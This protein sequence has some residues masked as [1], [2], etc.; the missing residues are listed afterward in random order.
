MAE[1]PQLIYAINGRSVRSETPRRLGFYQDPA[2]GHIQVAIGDLD[3]VAERSI[4]VSIAEL[5]Q[6]L[7]RIPAP[8]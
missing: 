6:A 7:N 8:D 2:P 5:R 4:V 3:N 1:R